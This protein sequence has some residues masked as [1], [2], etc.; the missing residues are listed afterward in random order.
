MTFIYKIFDAISIILSFLNQ[1]N[2]MFF[3]YFGW[4]YLS[5]FRHIVNNVENVCYEIN[6]SIIFVFVFQYYTKMHS[7]MFYKRNC[8]CNQFKR[9]LL[10]IH[11]AHSVCEQW[12]WQTYQWLQLIHQQQHWIWIQILRIKCD[13]LLC[14]DATS[15]VRS[16]LS[17]LLLSFSLMRAFCLFLFHVACGM[18]LFWLFINILHTYFIQKS[19]FYSFYFIF[20]GFFRVLLFVS[21]SYMLRIELLYHKFSDALLQC[22]FHLSITL[23]F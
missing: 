13:L 5:C 14:D 20:D 6:K 3:F 10:I 16:F 12:Q 7:W 9:I 19:A 1:I 2:T 18:Y 4:F 22:L 23:L 17:L 8:N 11:Y 21:T 15:T